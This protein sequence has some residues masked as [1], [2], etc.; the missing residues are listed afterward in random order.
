MIRRIP[1]V[2][3][4]ARQPRRPPM[5]DKLIQQG[6]QQDLWEHLPLA[7]RGQALTRLTDDHREGVQAFIQ[8]RA[9]EFT[10]H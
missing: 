2:S 6:Y 5:T 7:S 10:G 4:D 3:G 9:P 1:P 8:K